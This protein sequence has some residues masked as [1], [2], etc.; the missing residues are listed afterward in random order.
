MFKQTLILTIVLSVIFVSNVRAA[1]I[2]SN[3]VT[4]DDKGL[5]GDANNWSPQIV[6]DNNA[7]TTFAVTIDSRSGWWIEVGFYEKEFEKSYTI[8]TIDCYGD[9]EL[10]SSEWFWTYIALEHPNGL[11]NHGI[12]TIDGLDIKGNVRN[13]TGSEIYSEGDGQSITGNL[14]NNIGGYIEIGYQFGVDHGGSVDKGY[15]ENYGTIVIFPNSELY[16]D[17][18]FHNA[19]EIKIYDASCQADKTFYNHVNG[20]IYGFGNLCAW[21]TLNNEGIIYSTGDSLGVVCPSGM[22]NSGVLYNKP[23]TSLGIVIDTDSNN[24]GKIQVNTGGGITYD[25]NLV[26]D[27]NGIIELLG[28]TL[29]ATTITQ[30]ADANFVGFGSITGDVHIDSNGIIHLTG[31]TNI[32]GDVNIGTNAVLEVSDGTTLITGHT[33]N[34]GTIRM[35]GGRVIC[36]GGL[37]NNGNVEWQAGTDSCVADY[38]LDGQVNFKDFADFADTWLWQASWR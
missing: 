10:E 5:W 11:T 29:A 3:W 18:D 32:V 2:N 19:G 8:N 17:R 14:Y 33:T 13:M 25:C 34:N 37:T 28:G 9:V 16:S 26:N 4:I 31:P 27:S 6:P 12:L 22:V 24:T 30:T 7:S 15:I 23:N 38:N 35:I 21:Q 36:Q 1:Q 20:V